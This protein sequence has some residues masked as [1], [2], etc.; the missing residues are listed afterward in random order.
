MVLA[1]RKSSLPAVGGVTLALVLWA[2]PSVAWAQGFDAPQPL[3]N[4]LNWTNYLRVTDLEPDGDLDVIV[5][6]CGGF[7]STPPGP[8]RLRVY[9]NDLGVLTE[10]SSALLGGLTKPVRQVAV[11]DIDAD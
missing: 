6:N 5:A 3:D 1:V 11:G 10:V 7:F 4:D 9:R 8:Q 2:A